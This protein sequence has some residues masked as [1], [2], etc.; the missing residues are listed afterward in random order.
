MGRKTFD[1]IGHPL[2]NRKNIVITRNNSFRINDV[3]I[4]SSL[5]DAV[6][7]S[8]SFNKEVFIIGGGEI[9]NQAIKIAD[10][11]YLTIIEGNKNSDTF[12][13]DYNKFKQIIHKEKKIDSI[14]NLNYEY[15]I[16]E[17]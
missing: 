6:K 3:I 4:A 8:E 7:K 5:E 2:P 12:F 11:L 10:R 16:L 14:N 17:K 9:Y 1:S 15:I 13:P